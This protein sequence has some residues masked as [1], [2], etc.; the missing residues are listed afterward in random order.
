MTNAFV[1]T[2]LRFFVSLPNFGFFRRLAS[3][4]FLAQL[5]LHVVLVWPGRWGMKANQC[6]APV[7]SLQL[8]LKT[9]SCLA[10]RIHGRNWDRR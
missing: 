5:K 10:H 3:P 1:K 8:L 7:L 2:W 6:A 4:V 9:T